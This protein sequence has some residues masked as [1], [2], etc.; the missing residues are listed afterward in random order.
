METVEPFNDRSLES[1]TDCPNFQK[2]VEKVY[3]SDAFKDAAQDAA[4]FFR[5]VKDYVFNT[6]LTL[7]NMVSRH[8]SPAAR[9]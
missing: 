6:P 7:E 9:S 8:P 4:P 3:K 2:H 5:G 1:W